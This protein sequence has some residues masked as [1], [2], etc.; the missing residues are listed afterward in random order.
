MLPQ[1]ALLFIIPKEPATPVPILD[2]LTRRMCAEFRKARCSDYAYGG[3]HICKCGAVSS[4]NDYFLSN[5]DLTNSLCVHYVAYHRAEVPP[6]QLAHIE[7]FAAEEVEPTER[8]LQGTRQRVSEKGVVPVLEEY[9]LQFWQ[10]LMELYAQ[11]EVI[12]KQKELAVAELDFEK[13]A[14][15]RDQTN[16]LKK[17]KH[18]L[19]REWERGQL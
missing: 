7:G 4:S 15:L 11:I 9:P 13:A 1:Q 16:K 14:A 17:Q 2:H 10:T 3:V 6:V 19:M 18:E 5:G 12:N 8:E